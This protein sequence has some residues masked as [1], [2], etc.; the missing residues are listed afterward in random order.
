MGLCPPAAGKFPELTFAIMKIPMAPL[1]PTYLCPKMQ[2]CSIP[3]KFTWKTV[4]NQTETP[5]ASWARHAN[6]SRLN[7]LPSSPESYPRKS[8]H[9]F[10]P[11]SSHSASHLSPSHQPFL[12]SVIS[13]LKQTNKQK[14]KTN[15]QLNKAAL[16]PHL[17]PATAF[18]AFLSRDSSEICMFASETSL[19]SLPDASSNKRWVL[20]NARARF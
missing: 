6:F 17:L 12:H 5:S 2:R 3:G 11:V 8:G 7:P 14:T 9:P 15:P 10:C 4:S 18:L 1:I 20:I 13:P 16:F 19:P